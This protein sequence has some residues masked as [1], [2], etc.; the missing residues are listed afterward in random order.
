MSRSTT[1]TTR[2]SVPIPMSHQTPF[3]VLGGLCTRG[4]RRAKHVAPDFLPNN[5]AA[6]G[7][8]LLTGRARRFDLRLLESSLLAHGVAQVPCWVACLAVAPRQRR[9][10]DVAQHAKDEQGNECHHRS[11]RGRR[12]LFSHCDLCSSRLRSRRRPGR[13]FVRLSSLRGTV[14]WRRH[15]VVEQKRQ[16]GHDDNPKCLDAHLTPRVGL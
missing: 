15:Q 5:S 11:G 14:F 9:E 7:C 16:R 2:S 8:G 13:Q 10:G 12:N 4:A 6:R 3:A 1:S